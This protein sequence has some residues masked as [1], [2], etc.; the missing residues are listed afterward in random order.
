M[1]LRVTSNQATWHNTCLWPT[2]QGTMYISNC[3]ACKLCFTCTEVLQRDYIARALAL[4]NAP[5]N[6]LILTSQGHFKDIFGI[7]VRILGTLGYH[8]IESKSKSGLVTKITALRF[9][10]AANYETYI[11][12]DR[13]ETLDNLHSA[14][15]VTL[16]TVI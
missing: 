5:V 6:I 12:S 16:P 4:R 11:F 10:F 14:G 7:Y 13:S 8:A 15:C 9:H 1:L 3:T 2:V